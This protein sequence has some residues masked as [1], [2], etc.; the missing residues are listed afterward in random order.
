MRRW[1]YT[2]MGAMACLYGAVLMAQYVVIAYGIGWIDMYPPEQRDWWATLP[3]WAHGVFAVQA[4]LT[5]VGALCLVAHVRACVWMLGFAFIALLVLVVWVLAFA[6]PSLQALVGW[7]GPAFAAL[8]LALS[9]ALWL[10]ARG[11][12]QRGE[13]L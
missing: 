3:G 12:K 13:I 11:E 1:H 9:L 8:M 7:R 10:Y 4:L 5:L 6:E 2:L